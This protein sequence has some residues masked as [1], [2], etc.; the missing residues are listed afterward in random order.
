MSYCKPIWFGYK[1]LGV[2]ML[3]EKKKGGTL[4]RINFI[5]LLKYFCVQ[6]LIVNFKVTLYNFFFSCL[7]FLSDLQFGFTEYKQNDSDQ[8]FKAL[9]N[10][11]TKCAKQQIQKWGVH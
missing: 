3:K 6:F 2:T 9:D 1:R 7:K 11:L 8:N 5:P 10:P 4:L